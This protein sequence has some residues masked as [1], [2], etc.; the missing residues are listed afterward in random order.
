MV[1]SVPHQTPVKTAVPAWGEDISYHPPLPR[2]SGTA[3]PQSQSLLSS[4]CSWCCPAVSSGLQRGHQ[5]SSPSP[6]GTWHFCSR[7]VRGGW[8]KSEAESMPQVFPG[9]AV[10]HLAICATGTTEGEEDSTALAWSATLLQA[11]SGCGTP[12]HGHMGYQIKHP[13]PLHS[14]ALACSHSLPAVPPATSP[15]AWGVSAPWCPPLVKHTWMLPNLL[16]HTRAS[17]YCYGFTSHC[18]KGPSGKPLCWPKP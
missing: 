1:P 17:L 12:T 18:C 10:M 8:E 16:P 3:P 4:G 5:C 2:H 7:S 6:A 13:L 9:E 15:H 11:S 14:K